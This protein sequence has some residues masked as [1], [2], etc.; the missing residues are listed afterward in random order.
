MIS[1]PRSTRR[2]RSQIDEIRAGLYRLLEAENPMTV[3]QVFYRAVGEGLI[4]KS[5]TEYRATVIRLLTDLRR[6]G[7]MPFDWLADSTRWQRKPETWRS[8]EEALRITAETY[9]RA[10]WSTADSYVEIWLEKDALAGVLYEETSFFDVPLMVTRGYP[11]LTF[12]HSSA[13]ALARQKRPVFI[14]YFGD[15][16]PSGKDISRAVERDLRGFAPKAELYFERVAVNPAQIV[17]MGLPTRPT[18]KTDSRSKTFS[19][20]SVEVDAIPPLTLRK[21]ARKKIVSHLDLRELE[22]LEVAEEAERETLRRFAENFGR[23]A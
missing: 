21:M 11:S 20:E 19:G 1:R 9:R 16:D 4:E 22:R 18:K 13:A 7:V 23:A 10:L 8:L 12:L 17:S 6:S 3:R 2:T 5:E 14:Y 15:W